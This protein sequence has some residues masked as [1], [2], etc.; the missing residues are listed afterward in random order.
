MSDKEYSLVS[1]SSSVDKLMV[2]IKALDTEYLKILENVLKEDDYEDDMKMAIITSINKFMSDKDSSL[3]DILTDES[4][5]SV[6]F[7]ISSDEIFYKLVGSLPLEK[8][9]DL[10]GD[11]KFD[12]FT[13]RRAKYWNILVKKALSIA[14][15]LIM[16]DNIEKSYKKD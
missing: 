7:T 1:G 4:K 6:D 11:E 13:A 10:I 8:E 9:P 15:E 3:Y 16:F 5:K 12:V 2:F 14:D